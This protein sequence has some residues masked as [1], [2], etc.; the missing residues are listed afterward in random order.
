MAKHMKKVDGGYDIV[1]RAPGPYSHS[2]PTETVLLSFS[3]DD[4]AQFREDLKAVA[5]PAETKGA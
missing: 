3:D 4:M 2:E 5:P 1:E